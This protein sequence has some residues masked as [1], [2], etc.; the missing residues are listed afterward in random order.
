[1]NWQEISFR[2]AQD[3]EAVAS[4]LLPNGKREGAEWVAGS[5]DGESGRSL[6]VRISGSK[7]GV[8][9]DFAGD[10]GGDLIDLWAAT[11]GKTALEAFKEARAYLGISEP[12]FEAPRRA[13]SRPERPQCSKPSGRVLAYLIEERKLTSETLDAFKVAA[14][15][16]DGAIVLPYLRDGELVNIKHLALERDQNG[17]KRTWQAKDAEPCLFGWHLIGDDCRSVVITEG[18]FDSMSVHQYGFPALSINQGAGNHQWVEQDFERLSRFAEIFLWFDNDKAG[19][20][21]AH[22]VAKRLG[23]ERCRIVRHALKD[24][25]ECLQNGISQAEIRQTITQAERIEPQ[26]LRGPQAYTD[27]VLAMFNNETPEASGACFPWP[28]W[29]DK[30]R[31]RPAELS[32]WTGWNG[33]GKSEL[34]GHV[35]VDLIRQGE[36]VC[37]FS[38]E[39]RP[40]AVLYKMTRQACA[41]SSP[42]AS[43]VRAA[44]EWMTGALWIYDRIG[45][46]NQD[47]LIEAFRYAAKR[48]RCTHFLIDSLMKCGL[49]DDDYTGQKRFADRLCDFKNEF[50]VH[51]HLVA[52]AR[53]GE[54]EDRPPGK[55]DIKGSGGITD[56]ADN[57]F[58]VWRNKRK[59][60]SEQQDANQED[61]RLICHKQRA[62][63]WEGGLRL[64]FDPAS[65]QFKQSSDWRPRPTFD[66]SACM[67]SQD[68]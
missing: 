66:F 62:T 56:L 30:A 55:L 29:A 2:L 68:A 8:W 16:K 46:I 28:A 52:H 1:M 42:T 3:A 48:Y 53:K 58:T 64:W 22:E 50:G 14:D 11:R 49:A 7:A 12:H 51:V 13:Y 6:K 26:E 33:G 40:A 60:V 15:V 18:E 43:Y 21:G 38:G 31:M 4:M 45:S 61:A 57:V 25:N 27:A 35:C 5:T 23:F 32:V 24:A 59:E 65:R 17:K 41:I 10:Q 67:V 19:Q 44:H 20:D 36:R 9:C 47:A 34:L 37:I 54:S 63:G 39:M